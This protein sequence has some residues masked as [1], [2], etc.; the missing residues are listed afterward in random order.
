MGAITADCTINLISGHN[1]A[2]KE[3]VVETPATA[4]TGDTIVIDLGNYACSKLKHIVG[5]NH[6][7]TDSVLVTE[8]PTTAVSSGVLTITIGGTT[9]S[10][11]A[12]VYRVLIA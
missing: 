11:K 8:A 3:L 5:N 2:Y 9:S 1:Q 7:T 12:R 10:D 6:S 4:D